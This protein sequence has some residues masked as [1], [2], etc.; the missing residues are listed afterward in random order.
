M[1]K[2]DEG[3]K[4]LHASGGLLSSLRTEEGPCHPINHGAWE[5]IVSVADQI[6]KCYA[7]YERQLREDADWEIWFYKVFL[8]D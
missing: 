5:G 6:E 8:V 2:L 4:P 1:R 3:N 7:D